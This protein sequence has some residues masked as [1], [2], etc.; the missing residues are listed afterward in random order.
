M[1]SMHILCWSHID[2]L[3]FMENNSNIYIYI[4]KYTLN[5]KAI[6]FYFNIENSA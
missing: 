1:I 6:S 3:F 2:F 4:Y 5:A